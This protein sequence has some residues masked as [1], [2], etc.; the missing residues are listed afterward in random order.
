[1]WLVVLAYHKAGKADKVKEWLEKA[2]E[3]KE[4]E[5]TPWQERQA[6]ALWEREAKAAMPGAK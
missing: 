2:K 6:S 3:Q 4:R 5:G 1:V